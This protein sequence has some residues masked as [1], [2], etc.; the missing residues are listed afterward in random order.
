MS[1]PLAL[2]LANAGKSIAA[3]MAMMAMTTSN[4]IKVKA[5]PDAKLLESVKDL[6]IMDAPREH[7]GL[8]N[9]NSTRLAFVLSSQIL[10]FGHFIGFWFFQSYLMIRISLAKF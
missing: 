5:A 7:K 8:E 6:R 1:C 9:V 4:S 2:A 3:N 10:V